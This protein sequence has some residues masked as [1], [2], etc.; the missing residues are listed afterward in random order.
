MD[1]TL[2]TVGPPRDRGLFLRLLLATA[3]L[4]IAGRA[5]DGWWHAR[6]DE[7]EARSSW[8]PLGS[9]G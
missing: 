7:F 9:S 5:L 8:K 6:H 2:P 3:V 4:E 1:R